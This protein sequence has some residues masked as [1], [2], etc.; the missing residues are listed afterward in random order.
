MSR[1]AVFPPSALF[2]PPSASAPEPE[3]AR[4]LSRRAEAVAAEARRRPLTAKAGRNWLR[5]A[6]KRAHG[7]G[8]PLLARRIAAL[9]QGIV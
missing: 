7:L 8:L 6:A 2:V 9:E 1:S 3:S 5:L 4:F